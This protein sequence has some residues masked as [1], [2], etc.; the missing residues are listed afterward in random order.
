MN[1]IYYNQQLFVN[2]IGHAIGGISKQLAAT[3]SMTFQNRVALDMLLAEKGGIYAM[4]GDSCWTI[5]PNNTALD[6]LVAHTLTKLQTLINRL[7][8]M[9]GYD[10]TGI[11]GWFDTMFGKWKSII[12]SLIISLGAVVGVL[13]LCWCCIITC[14][15]GLMTR[16]I[17]SSITKQIAHVLVVETAAWRGTDIPRRLP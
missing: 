4:F 12:L 1:L 7:K 9:S 6:G 11:W 15:R 17:E 10:D 14:V 3:S 5:I 8:Q 2:A 16:V 13:N